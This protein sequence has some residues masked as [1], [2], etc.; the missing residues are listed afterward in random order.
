[1]MFYLRLT[2][3]TLFGA[4]AA[5][6]V[7]LVNISIAGNWLH[8]GSAL[9]EYRCDGCQ[10]VFL[11]HLR[12]SAGISLLAALASVAPLAVVLR[13]FRIRAAVSIPAILLGGSLASAVVQAAGQLDMWRYFTQ[14]WVLVGPGLVGSAVFVLMLL[15]SWRSRGPARSS[16]SVGADA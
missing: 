3:A 2:F 4:L 7:Y 12:T 1:M 13:A 11:I 5:G 16:H 14:A 10:A 9:A 6:F 15:P 8:L